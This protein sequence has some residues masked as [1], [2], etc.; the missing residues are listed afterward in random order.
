MYLSAF[1]TNVP[2]TSDFVNDYQSNFKD[3]FTDQHDRPHRRA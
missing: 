1:M 2:P 3:V